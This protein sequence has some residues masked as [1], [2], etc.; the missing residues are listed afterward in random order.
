MPRSFDNA[1]STVCESQERYCR[2][3][4]MSFGKALIH[5]NGSPRMHLFHL[6]YQ[7]SCKVEI[8]YRHI[9]K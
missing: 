8:M 9:K 1:E 2:V 7:E 5:K 3:G 4:I 6:T